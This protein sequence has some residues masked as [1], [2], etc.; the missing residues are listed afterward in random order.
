MCGIYITNMQFE[1]AD[2]RRNLESIRFRGPDNTGILKMDGLILGH[3]RLSILD[4]DERSHQPMSYEDLAIVYNGEIY[5]YRDIRKELSGRG[6]RFRTASDTE[7]ILKGYREWGAELIPR[8]NGMFS[9]ALYDSS[10]RKVFCSRDRLGVKPFYY[11]WNDGNFEICSQL[12]PIFSRRKLSERA[13]SIFLDCTYIPSPYTVYEDIYKLPP[14]NNLEI[15]LKT[16]ELEIREYWNL[17]EADPVGISYDQARDQLHELMIDAVGIRLYADVPFGTFLSGGIDSALVTGIASKISDSPIRTFS[18]GFEDP[19]Y[20]ESRVA[21]QYA[22]LLGTDHTE[23]TC[24]HEDVLE[25]VPDLVRVYDEPFADSSAL[26]TLLLNKVTREYVTMALSGDGGDES[27]LGYNHFEWLGK[28]L[29]FSSL[30][31]FLRRSLSKFLVFDLFGRRT[32]KIKKIMDIDSADEFIRSVFTGFD[33]ILKERDFSWFSQYS[34]Y[35]RK[36]AH[37]LQRSADLNIKLW[38]ENDSNVKVDRASMA[39]SVEVRSPFLDYRV[40]EFARTLPVSYRYSKGLRKRITR[41]ILK[42]Y[43]P[44]E[45]FDQPKKGFSAPVA[46]WIRNELR[47]EF[48]KN[49]SDR[50]LLQVPNLDADKFKDMMRMHMSGRRDHSSYI[51][52]LYV[53]SKWFQEFGFCEKLTDEES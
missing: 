46:S 1:E 23:I 50:F 43:V 53:L 42:D 16:G 12:R 7:V 9:F 10:E 25:L 13:I 15:D 19:E 5:N 31:L 44:E 8:L 32:D 2:V 30:P 41:D 27:F 52:R 6:Y 49:L 28:F 22:Q 51:W 47:D 33:S 34:D 26:P 24:S 20:D 18:V 39:Y 21:A 35:R 3:L 11:Y 29:A 45:I 17:K 14:G 40:I 37:P 48:R 4:L 38:L 36:A